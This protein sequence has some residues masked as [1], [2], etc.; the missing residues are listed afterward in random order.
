MSVKASSSATPLHALAAIQ[1]VVLPR[2]GQYHGDLISSLESMVENPGALAGTALRSGPALVHKPE[3]GRN[4][5]RLTQLPIEAEIHC[6]TVDCDNQ[7]RLLLDSRDCEV[8]PYC[9]ACA[10]VEFA[11]WMVGV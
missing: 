2:P 10:H 5:F 4:Y 6:S 1:E 11:M 9:R 8:L 7:A 3:S